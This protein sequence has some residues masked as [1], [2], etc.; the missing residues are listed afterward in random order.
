MGSQRCSLTSASAGQDTRGKFTCCRKAFA[1]LWRLTR[2]L[3][4]CVLLLLQALSLMATMLLYLAV[5]AL[6]ARNEP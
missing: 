3:L 4:L 5:R 1:S 2:T 6:T